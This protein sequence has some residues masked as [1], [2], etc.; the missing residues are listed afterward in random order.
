MKKSYDPKKKASKTPVLRNLQGATPSQRKEFRAQEKIRIDALQAEL[1]D[2]V[3]V[4]SK[5]S[6]ILRIHS[7]P[8][9]V[10]ILGC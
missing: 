2:K 9:V 5:V 8:Y 1:G 3:Y 4:P 6:L 7:F 10:K